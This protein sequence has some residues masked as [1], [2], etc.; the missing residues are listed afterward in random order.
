MIPLV[1]SAGRN[2]HFKY[3]KNKNKP[4]YYSVK[5][6]SWLNCKESFNWLIKISIFHLGINTLPKFQRTN[7]TLFIWIMDIK[8]WQQLLQKHTRHWDGERGKT[9]ATYSCYLFSQFLI[10]TTLLGCVLQHHT[11]GHHLKVGFAVVCFLPHFPFYP[12][13]FKL[14]LRALNRDKLFS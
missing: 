11:R 4:Y 9:L 3:R 1:W 14:L 5:T 12:V 10:S 13:H 7:K 2:L 6:A 8:Y